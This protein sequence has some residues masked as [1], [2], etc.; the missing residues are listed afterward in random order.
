[1][2]PKTLAGLDPKLRETYE[3]VM[4][5]AASA[6]PQPAN[7]ASTG[8]T[9]IISN[10]PIPPPVAPQTATETK[11]ADTASNPAPAVP[12]EQKSTDVLSSSLEANTGLS[13]QPVQPAD[14]SN[15]QPS[16]S[17]SPL[18]G[19]ESAAILSKP[20]QPLPSPASVNHQAAQTGGT[21]GVLKIVY[22]IAG[23]IFFI[24]YAIFWMKIFNFPLPF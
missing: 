4:G 9:A 24:V 1:M 12:A 10:T 17:G 6:A 19:N 3:K 23:V 18:P 7:P 21:S 13:A 5:T 8:P 2:D 16:L 11:P 15:L 20:L 22:I 14:M